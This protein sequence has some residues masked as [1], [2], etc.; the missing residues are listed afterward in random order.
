[1]KVV[2]QIKLALEGI[3]KCY[4]VVDDKTTVSTVYDY[5][6]HLKIYCLNQ[7]NENAKVEA[8]AENKQ[9]EG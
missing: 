1:M 2:N 3:D 5:A 9:S 8:E 4:L 6:C 7:M